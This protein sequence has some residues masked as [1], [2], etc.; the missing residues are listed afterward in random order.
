MIAIPDMWLTQIEIT[1]ACFKECINCTRFVGHHKKPYF[2]DLE[3]V[4]KAIDSLEGFPGGVGIMGGEPTM[5]P[6]FDEICNLIRKKVPPERR[7]LW[8]S[9]YKWKDHRSVIRKTFADRIY[10]NEHKDVTQK[11]QPM[12]IAI[13]D[14]LEDKNYMKELVG[15]CW[16][17]ERWSA[18]INPKGCFFCEIAAA[19]DVMFEGPGG[20]P[21]EKGWWDKTPEQFQDQVE[22]YCY[23]CSAAL[24]LP[25]VHL[26]EKKD[27]V[28]I[29]NYKRLEELETPKFLKNRVKLIEKSYS[30]AEIEEFAK[31]WAPWAYI[32]D[33]GRGANIYKIYGIMEARI[34]RT[35][36]EIRHK[37]QK[38]YNIIRADV[39]LSL[40]DFLQDKKDKNKIESLL[41]K[42][43][44]LKYK[45]ITREHSKKLPSE[46]S[47]ECVL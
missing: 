4:E 41:L 38:K 12:L 46:E 43:L 47:G 25:P 29:S 16:M 9:G 28:S 18:S 37:I 24:P 20:Y 19:Q 22:R 40:R 30:K 13:D 36:V 33:E 7:Y 35:H 32:G 45:I 1:N 15:R 5:H 3:L 8:S 44:D 34:L 26:K 42:I 31:D 14:L 6:K 2:M 11:H 17:Q 23:K 39:S 21:I 10:Y 27:Y